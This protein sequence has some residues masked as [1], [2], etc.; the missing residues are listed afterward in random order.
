MPLTDTAL[1]NLKPSGKPQSVADERGLSIHILP[2]GSKWWRF[3]Y[4]FNDKAKMLSLGVCLKEA[5]E[6]REAARKMLADVIDPGETRKAQKASKSECA[7]NSFEVIAREWLEGQKSV[8]SPGHHEKTL[9]R[10]QND[11]FPWLGTKPMTEISAPDVLS[12][13]V[14]MRVALVIQLTDAEARLAKSHAT[15]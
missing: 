9:A 12:A 11:V 13:A 3:R 15:P 8:V 14:S 10:L 1:R 7:A 4:R 6:R 2:N 5:R